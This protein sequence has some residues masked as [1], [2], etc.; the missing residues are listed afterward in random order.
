MTERKCIYFLGS[1]KW[2]SCV[3][4][5]RGIEKQVE[6]QFPLVA[7]TSH[8]M[9]PPALRIGL[10]LLGAVFAPGTLRKS[11]CIL[12][13]VGVAISQQSL[14]RIQTFTLQT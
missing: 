11:M 8:T 4:P 12:H 9:G 3:F 10:W 5:T 6:T 13:N 2:I 7:L 1:G 14:K